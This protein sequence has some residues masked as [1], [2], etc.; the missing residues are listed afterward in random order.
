LPGDQPAELVP[1]RATWPG[2]AGRPPA[3]LLVGGDGIEVVGAARDGA[4]AVELAERLRP[5]V[6]LMDLNMPVLDGVTATALL[7][8][9][10]A[11]SAVLVLTT[12][13]DDDSVFPALRAGAPGYLTKDADDDEVEAAIHHV[14][15]GRTWRDP[16]VQARLDIAAPSPAEPRRR[17]HPGYEAPHSGK[18][19]RC[20]TAG[21]RA[22]PKCSP[23]LLRAC[24]M[25][26]SAPG[27]SWA[28]PR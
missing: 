24:P 11:D 18:P 15:G 20:L 4:E 7:R 1:V 2:R 22:K 19:A 3:Y 16:V 21:R 14:H 23:S 8:E 6:V 9:M 12:Y 28:R 17:P 10:A 13:A 25:L 5:D 26:R 27:S